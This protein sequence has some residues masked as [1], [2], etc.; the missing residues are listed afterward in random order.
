MLTTLLTIASSALL[1][2]E[3]RGAHYRRDFPETNN[4]RWLQNTVVRQK[5][6]D[7]DV[8]TAPVRSTTMRPARADA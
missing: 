8:G 4:A 3:S 2:E 6:E 5:A 7:L 1:R